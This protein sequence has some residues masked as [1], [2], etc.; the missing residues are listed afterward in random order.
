M[1]ALKTKGGYFVKIVILGGAGGQG[2][3]STKEI[4]RGGVFDEIVVAS[5]N[6]EKTQE[7]VDQLEAPNVKAAQIDVMDKEALVDLISDADVVANCTGPYY[8][9]GEYVV[10]AAI[11]AGVNYIDFCDD[12]TVHKALFSKD[13]HERAKEKNISM[14]IGLGASPG[15]MPL[16]AYAVAKEFDE[17]DDIDFYM[18]IDA[19]DDAE[20]PAVLLHVIENFVDDI[21]VIRDAKVATEKPFEGAIM[22][23]FEGPIGEVMIST[24][25]HPEVF[26][27]PR[28]LPEA[29]NITV[30]LGFYPSKAFE[31]MRELIEAG[32]ATEEALIVNGKEVVL[33]DFLVSHMIETLDSHEAERKLG[34]P[35][36]GSVVRVTGIKDGKRIEYINR[37]FGRMGPATGYPLAIGAEMLA[38]GKIEKKGIMVP[39]ECIDA[40]PFLTEFATR[41]AKAGHLS[42]GRTDIKTEEISDHLDLMDKFDIEF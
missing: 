17:V 33:R 34:Q 30:K 21:D 5:R 6:L 36:T 1:V 37:S 15:V 42:L 38:Q 7:I 11:E 40:I 10:E 19:Q 35:V 3:Y 12:V 14:I 24:M 39:E 2:L 4:I 22:Y 8:L 31:Y 26:T 32:L 16:Q 27:I 25:G 28:V 41:S 23:D 18:G 13:Y 29:K 9:L 20:G